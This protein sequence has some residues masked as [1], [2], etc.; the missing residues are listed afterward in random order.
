M[1]VDQP[2]IEQKHSNH[3]TLVYLIIMQDGK[4]PKVDKRAVWIKSVQVGIFQKLLSLKT[5][6]AGNFPKLIN[7]Q[8]GIRMCRLDF[9]KKLI[10]CAARLLD[11]L[12]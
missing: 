12:E 9:F 10:S 6:L 1:T 8:D 11:R 3:G 5:L 7:V 4:I 2:I